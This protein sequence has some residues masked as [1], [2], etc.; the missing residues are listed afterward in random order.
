MKHQ[1]SRTEP[2]GKQELSF[3]DSF[4]VLLEIKK[5]YSYGLISAVSVVA[6]SKEVARLRGLSK[7]RKTAHI[8]C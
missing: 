3:F 5:K 7:Q 2:S 6:Q 8:T 1:H 4:S